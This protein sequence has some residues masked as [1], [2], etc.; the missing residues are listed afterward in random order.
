MPVTYRDCGSRAISSAENR[1]LALLLEE[2]LTA[3]THLLSLD[4]L[5][6]H[7]TRGMQCATEHECIYAA[8]RRCLEG[9]L[10]PSRMSGHTVEKV[11]GSRRQTNS[12]RRILLRCHR[13]KEASD[14][15]NS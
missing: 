12:Y 14:F 5:F 2:P 1:L 9:F 6:S 7:S 15:T 13:S 3:G 4:M 11:S 10:L 8:D